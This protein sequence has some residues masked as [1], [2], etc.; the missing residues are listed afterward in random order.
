MN[1]KK[2]EDKAA[3]KNTSLL[4]GWIAVIVI[5]SGLFWAFTQPLRNRLLIRSVNRVLEQSGDSRRLG[6]PSFSEKTSSIGLGS[7]YTVSQT[8]SSN[9]YF[10]AGTKALIFTFIGEGTF[11]PCAAL[12]N[13]EGKVLEFIPLNRHGE[14]VL[15][16]LSPGI[17]K[18][19]IKR[20][21][22][23]AS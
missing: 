18:L 16:R 7:W 17:L 12:T 23:T 20:I 13:G 9:N 1:G 3:I 2:N 6:D 15:K 11:F 5:L 14:R 21:E 19:Y 10:Q 22:G 4:I 8:R